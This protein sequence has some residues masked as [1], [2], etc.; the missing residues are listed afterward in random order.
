MSNYFNDVKELEETVEK[1]VAAAGAHCTSLSHS[2]VLLLTRGRYY[3]RV[4][5]SSTHSE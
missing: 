3:E 4:R 5:Q 2:E 1:D